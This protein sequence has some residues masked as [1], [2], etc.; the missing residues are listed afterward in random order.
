MWAPGQ[1]G[2]AAGAPVTYLGRLLL[3]AGAMPDP[4]VAGAGAVFVG[5]VDR[6]RVVGF[7]NWLAFQAQEAAGRLNYLGHLLPRGHAPFRQLSRTMPVVTTGYLLPHGWR[8]HASWPKCGQS[9]PVAG[10]CRSIPRDQTS[11]PHLP[12]TEPR[13]VLREGISA[14]DNADLLR[15]D[16]QSSAAL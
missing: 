2:Q 6:G 9:L 14:Q 13:H 10:A 4:D 15:Y 7:H 8:V 12:C 16:C 11:V 5:E 3:T 1:V